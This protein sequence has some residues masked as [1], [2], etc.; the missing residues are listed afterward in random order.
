MLCCVEKTLGDLC[1][2]RSAQTIGK[3]IGLTAVNNASDVE[4][5]DE[6]YP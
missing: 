5:I 2:N 6:P 3:T 1:R 4:T